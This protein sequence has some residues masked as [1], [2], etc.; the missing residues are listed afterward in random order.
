M[1]VLWLVGGYSLSFADGNAFIGGLADLVTAAVAADQ[2]KEP[3]IESGAGGRICP[4][5]CGRCGQAW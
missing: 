3:A 2:G 5:T 4:Q 1:T